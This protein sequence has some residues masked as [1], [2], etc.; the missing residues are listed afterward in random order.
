M[1]RKH[2]QSIDFWKGITILSVLNIH[3]RIYLWQGLATSVP[4]LFIPSLIKQGVPGI[5]LYGITLVWT[6]GAT[7]GITLCHNRIESLLLRGKTNLQ[8]AKEIA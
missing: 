2:L 3:F 8:A 5:A 6:V 4:Y 1:N 7:L